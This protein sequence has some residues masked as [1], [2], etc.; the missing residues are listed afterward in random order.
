MSDLSL[1]IDWG[2]VAITVGADAP[3]DKG[4]KLRRIRNPRP[5]TPMTVAQMLLLCASGDI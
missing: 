5:A 1:N 3:E 2:E 4:F